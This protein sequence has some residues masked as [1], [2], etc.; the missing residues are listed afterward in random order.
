[1]VFQLVLIFFE[2]CFFFNRVSSK[3]DNNGTIAQN[4]EATQESNEQTQTQTSTAIQSKLGFV[5]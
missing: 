1:M 4:P 3:D 5:F 2:L